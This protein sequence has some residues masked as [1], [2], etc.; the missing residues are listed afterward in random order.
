MDRPEPP[1]AEEY[2]LVRAFHEQSMLCRYS[3]WELVE[4]KL[5]THDQYILTL[6]RDCDSLEASLERRKQTLY[7]QIQNRIEQLEDS[8]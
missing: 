5:R 8:A 1:T 4:R 7:A 6:I 2:R 3:G